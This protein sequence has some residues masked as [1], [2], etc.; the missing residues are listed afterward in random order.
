MSESPINKAPSVQGVVGIVKWNYYNAAAI[1]GYALK[2]NADK[3]TWT[4]R[5]R[6]VM[7]DR[8]KLSQKGLMFVAP[9]ARG[10][11]RWP[12]EEFNIADGIMTARL[13]AVEE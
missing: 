2:R 5:A 12:I 3:R 9:H 7:T 4:L 10:Q 11:W 6:V 8:F 1:E 13:G